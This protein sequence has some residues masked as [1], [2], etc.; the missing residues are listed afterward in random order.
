MQVHS[1]IGDEDDFIVIVRVQIRS[2]WLSDAKSHKPTWGLP[3]RTVLIGGV[4]IEPVLWGRSA[5]DL[6]VISCPRLPKLGGDARDVRE[7]L[8][9][10]EVGYDVIGVR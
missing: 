7:K 9:I 2:G 8:V 5:D 10:G 3:A 6:R 1:P 4:R